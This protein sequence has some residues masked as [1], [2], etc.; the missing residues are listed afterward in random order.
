MKKC[1]LSALL[2][3]LLS[4]CGSDP[5]FDE[6]T[7]FLNQVGNLQF[8]NLISDSPELTITHRTAITST[9]TSLGFGESSQVATRAVDTYNW[10]ARYIPASGDA[11]TVV[12]SASSPLKLNMQHTIILQGTASNASSV[13]VE[14][15]VVTTD[16]IEDG[17][18]EVWFAAGTGV[19]AMIDIYIT[20]NDA[21][22]TGVEPTETL[23]ASMHSPMRHTL[24]TPMG[25]QIR[26][27]A[28]AT[29]TPLLFDSGSLDF[30]ARRRHFFAIIVAAGSPDAASYVDVIDASRGASTGP[31]VNMARPT[32]VRVVNTT[33]TAPAIVTLGTDTNAFALGNIPGAVAGTVASPYMTTI[34][35]G[36]QKIIV[37][38]PATN[39]P[40]NPAPI[41]SDMD[42]LMVTLVTGRF[43]TIYLFDDKADN[44]DPP[45]IA[46]ITQDDNRTLVGRVNLRIVHGSAETIDLF[47]TRDGA[48]IDDNTIP[49]NNVTR[50]A[51]ATEIAPGMITFTVTDEIDRSMVRG[52][53]LTSTLTLGNSYTLVIDADFNLLLDAVAT[54]TSSP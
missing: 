49:V 38:L 13:M 42:N 10:Q 6:A 45:I 47:V 18:A 1:R 15:P 32:M 24:D 29:K 19:P 46:A 30:T 25:R 37:T 3:L 9:N 28:A 50:S 44:A 12:E 26:I 35:T 8:V 5:G 22:L 51:V 27:T 43:N 2:G 17:K 14:H 20:E 41:V 40:T 23:A 39:P 16:N 21:D 31:I 4:A 11:V 53:A 34:L 54:A 48:A 33:A 52:T 36:E 7:V